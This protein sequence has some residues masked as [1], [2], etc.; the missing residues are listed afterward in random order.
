MQEL[1]V[2]Q[3]AGLRRLFA[4]AESAF[5]ELDD[6]MGSGLMSDA[7]SAVFA[8]MEAAEALALPDDVAAELRRLAT[9]SWQGV[10]GSGDAYERTSRAIGAI[11]DLERVIAPLLAQHPEDE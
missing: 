6:A 10:T 5:R 7:K 2:E 1:S 9:L 8:M 3:V 11:G 4:L